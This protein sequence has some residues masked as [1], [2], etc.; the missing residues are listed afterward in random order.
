MSEVSGNI[1]IL[2]F[3]LLFQAPS[4]VLKLAT[5]KGEIIF[6]ELRAGRLEI[7]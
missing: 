1:I 5:T 2:S 3:I 4:R 7:W 6:D